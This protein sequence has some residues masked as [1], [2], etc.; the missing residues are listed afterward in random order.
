MLKLKINFYS[1]YL[2]IITLTI[3]L[4]ISFLVFINIFLIGFEPNN[5]EIN[6]FESNTL[7]KCSIN[8]WEALDV[9]N[10]L[11]NNSKIYFEAYDLNIF[12]QT[13]NFYCL[14]KVIDVKNNS[15]NKIIYLGTNRYLF[16]FF[17]I[18]INLSL[19]VL[20]LGNFFKNR[21]LGI[22]FFIFNF[23]NFYLFRSELTILKSIFPYTNPQ[24]Y[25]E[26]FV[27]NVIFLCL[28]FTKFKNDKLKIIFI[29]SL[30]LFI[31]DYFGLFVI[32][33]LIFTNRKDFFDLNDTSNDKLLTYLPVTYYIIRTIYSFNSY[34]DNFWMLSG[35]RVYHGVSRYYDGLWNFEAMACIKNP[36]IFDGSNKICRELRAGILDDYIYITT[37]PY[38]TTLF[39]MVAMHFFIVYIYFDV[40][41]RFNFNK[42]YVSLMFV[43]PAF[44]FLTYQG[45]FDVLF[46][47]VAY[48]SLT[49]LKRYN[50]LIS[51]VFFFLSLYKLHTLGA[52]FGLVLYFLKQKNIRLVYTNL[53]LFS[54]SLFFALSEIIEGKIVSGFGTFEYS[55]G[56]LNLANLLNRYLVIGDY[57]IYFVILLFLFLFTLLASKFNLIEN[58]TNE[59]DE[60]LFF[61]VYTYWFL[62]TLFTVNNSY[63]IPIFFLILLIYM[64]SNIK[65]LRIS[66]FLF[67]FLSIIPIT[68]YGILINLL[69]FI[70]YTSMI[71]IIIS[72][73]FLEY[74][75]T[76]SRLKKSGLLFSGKVNY[77]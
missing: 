69:I 36:N 42:L 52:I 33:F 41:K 28:L 37:E 44:N 45:N 24:S 8:K 73:L 2:K 7:D 1:K 21:F 4:L 49:K 60:E 57:L 20:L 58:L 66:T 12:P 13:D 47:V 15:E 71:L 63:R 76:I 75:K 5:T 25:N 68:S 72:I 23:F 67:V 38:L 64:E 56:I 17:N 53:I 10:F 77:D 46:L 31:P 14:G 50:L 11:S 27:L 62:F 54:I 74:I 51:L 40:V 16:N 34:F 59:F 18:V 22:L 61:Y 30:V 32:I 19:I 29:Y 9:K 55:Y 70:K 65:L 48:I 3:L 35:Q 43:S 39:F 6:A 26:V